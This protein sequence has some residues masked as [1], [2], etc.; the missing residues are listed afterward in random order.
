MNRA[1]WPHKFERMK[2]LITREQRFPLAVFVLLG[3]VVLMFP[4]P[5]SLSIVLTRY[6]SPAANIPGVELLSEGML[7]L[8]ASTA[9]TTMVFAWRSHPRRRVVVSAG[10]IGVVLA[11][12]SSE[13]IKSLISQP[14]PCQLWSIKGECPPFGDWSL[15]SNHAALAFGAVWVIA[16]ATRRVGVTWFAICAAALVAMA[17]VM[18]GAH[19]AHDVSLGALLGLAIPAAISCLVLAARKKPHA[20]NLNS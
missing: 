16:L 7:L 2:T 8:L 5:G 10:A 1:S 4:F 17:R 18:Q 6:L 19:Y 20:R 13:S 9:A 12:L 15:P 3:A 11:Y 14:R